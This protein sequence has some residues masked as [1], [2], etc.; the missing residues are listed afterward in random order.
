MGAAYVSLSKLP[1]RSFV[2]LGPPSA[3]RAELSGS[4]KV[5]ADAP[6]DHRMRISQILTIL[7]DSLGLI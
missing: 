2:V 1:T 5:V 4:D 3:I 7:T 6:A